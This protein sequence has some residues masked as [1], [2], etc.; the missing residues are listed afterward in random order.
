MAKKDFTGMQTGRVYEELE[1]ATSGNRQTDATEKEF[2]MRSAELRTQGR[3]GC[4][5]P[6]INMAFTVDNYEFIRVMSKATGRTMTQFVNLVI[7]AYRKEHPDILAQAR[8]FLETVNSGIFS[9]EK[10]AQYNDEA[11]ANADKE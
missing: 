2:L 4:K 5:A 10:E 1:E 6:R 9:A 8:G 11:G 3:Q 7:A